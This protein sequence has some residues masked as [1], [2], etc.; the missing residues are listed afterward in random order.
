M[1]KLFTLSMMTALAIQATAQVDFFDD[2]E[3]YTP[4]E[5]L[6]VQSEVWTTWSN[7]DGTSE[8]VLVSDENAFSGS[9][10]LHFVSTA[11]G[12]G[13]ADV[14]LPMEQIYSDGLLIISSQMYITQNKVGYFNIQGTGTPGQI[15]TL[16]FTAE[17]GEIV[18][19][20][21]GTVYATAYYTPNEWFEWRIQANMSMNI[22]EFYINDELIHTFSNVTNA[23]GSVDL[24][25][26]ENADFYIDDVAYSWE[27][28]TL[29]ELNLSILSINNLVGVSGIPSD[30]VAVVRNNGQNEV[31]SFE[32]GVQH[33]DDILTAV[34]DGITL[35]TGEIYEVDFDQDLNLPG[36]DQFVY[37]YIS[38]VNGGPDDYPGDDTV[39]VHINVITPANGRMVAAEEGTGTWC[40]WCPRGAVAMEYLE[41]TYQQYFVGIA[42]HNQDPMAVPAYDDGLG[43]GAF[44]GGKV[45]RGSV[46]DPGNFEIDF[47]NRITTTPAAVMSI[48]AELEGDN[49]LKVVV[50]ADLLESLTGNYKL[51]FVVTEDGVTGTSGGYAQANY[52]TGG[53]SG[54]MGGYENLGDPVPAS[55]MVYNDVARTILPGFTG[56]DAIFAEGDLLAGETYSMNFEVTI[57]SSWEMDNLE[58]V[59]LLLAPNGKINNA[60]AATMDEALDNGWFDSGISVGIAENLTQPDAVVSIYPNPATDNSFVKLQLDAAAEVSVEIVSTTGKVVGARNY[61]QLSGGVI[62]PVKTSDLAS[63]IY[64]L[65]VKT[66]NTMST[67]KLVVK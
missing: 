29:P 9:N 52:Y 58:L 15:W 27:P 2:F 64:L 19:S 67:H 41:E 59:A 46:M 66:G 53:T 11:P 4:D 47:L 37:A 13:P 40:G 48:G 55:Q 56:T 62:L 36:G 51:A 39:A 8:D 57:P 21:S 50:S 38:S 26:I 31:N 18:L 54:P 20:E 10:S 25:S 3:S 30:V 32:V 14:I 7:A 1:K 24:F 44:P 12:G 28:V 5:Y 22:W 6:G 33:G 16:D 49:L 60:G 23:I 63:G 43:L 65:K 45:D 17:D 34:V 35:S 61:G 42:V